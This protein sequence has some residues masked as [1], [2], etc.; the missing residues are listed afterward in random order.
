MES[1]PTLSVESP[2][3]IGI[4]SFD[5]IF[6]V[7]VEG[8]TH[9]ISGRYSVQ[10]WDYTN[11]SSNAIVDSFTPATT[12]YSFCSMPGETF[13]FLG[14]DDIEKRSKSGNTILDNLDLDFPRPYVIYNIPQTTLVIVLFG[15]R[16]NGKLYDYFGGFTFLELII[17]VKRS[18]LMI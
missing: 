10:F 16:E 18:H 9:V 12:T 15:E 17:K 4:A 3:D 14:T 8:T 11:V 6:A 13:Y 5:R 1:N 2:I 7:I